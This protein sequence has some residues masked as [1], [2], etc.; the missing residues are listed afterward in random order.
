MTFST[1]HLYGTG[2]NEHHCDRE[3]FDRY[4]TFGDPSR[5]QKR[6]NN[7][8]FEVVTSDE[9]VSDFD[10]E[11]WLADLLVTHWLRTHN[12]HQSKELPGEK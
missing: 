12:K 11:T 4:W 9:L 10:F 6:Q 5:D 7:W 2:K 1:M 3:K 8:Q